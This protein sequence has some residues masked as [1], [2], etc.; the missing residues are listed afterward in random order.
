MELFQSPPETQS[1][2]FTTSCLEIPN[3]NTPMQCQP[4]LQRA[5]PPR[6]AS[7]DVIHQF[8]PWYM[9][10]AQKV[11]NITD[12]QSSLWC[13]SLCWVSPGHQPLFKLATF[14]ILIS[15]DQ[16]WV[17]IPNSSHSATLW[18][19]RFY[20]SWKR[21]QLQPGRLRNAPLISFSKSPLAILSFSRKYSLTFL[22]LEKAGIKYFS[23]NE[24]VCRYFIF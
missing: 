16:V 15:S 22:Q 1:P 12:I 7:S 13:L 11:T 14:A 24:K 8:Y 19:A 3:S 9:K 5:S 6:G 20:T 23:G 17:T 2:S 10:T 18:R 4:A 21:F